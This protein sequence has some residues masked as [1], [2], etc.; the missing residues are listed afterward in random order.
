MAARPVTAATGP[1]APRRASA[2]RLPRRARHPRGGRLRPDPLLLGQPPQRGV[3]VREELQP[4]PKAS[5]MWI[6]PR[7]APRTLANE[8]VAHL[9]H[10]ASR[11]RDELTGAGARGYETTA[12]GSSAWTA[13]PSVTCSSR[14]VPGRWA[15]TSFSIFIA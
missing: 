14:T 3:R 8:D 1:R 12:M 4:A 15:A 6:W 7:S 11:A 10:D 5:A 2:G 9:R 13:W